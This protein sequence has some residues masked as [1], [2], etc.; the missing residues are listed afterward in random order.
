MATLIFSSRGSGS[1]RNRLCV[2]FL[3]LAG[4][5]FPLLRKRGTLAGVFRVAGRHCFGC[6]CV[7][8]GSVQTAL[9]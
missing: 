3:F 1:G 6:P 7:I 8:S 4:A 5:R 9:C 2:Q